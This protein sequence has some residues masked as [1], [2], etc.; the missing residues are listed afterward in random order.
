MASLQF[1]ISF[2]CVSNMLAYNCFDSTRAPL[3]T[4]QFPVS[5]PLVLCDAQV[6]SMLQ[7]LAQFTDIQVALAVG[8]LS[9]T[10]QAATL[11]ASPEVV[12]ATPV[13][14]HYLFS[15][16]GNRLSQMSPH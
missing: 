5:C 2:T 6:H 1:G 11:R 12:V 4:F 10:V 9:L 8:G 14:P 15:R 3:N 13:R 16:L 7:K